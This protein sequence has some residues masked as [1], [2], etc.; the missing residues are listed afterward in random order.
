M[1]ERNNIG[2]WIDTLHALREKKTKAERVVDAVK[3]LIDETEQV[4]MTALKEAGLESARGK[5]L[6]ATLSPRSYPQ[7]EDYEKLVTHI[8]KTGAFELLQR[9]LSS[10][11]VRE[12]W[13]Q[14][15]V[16]P[17]VIAFRTTELSLTAVT[18][19]GG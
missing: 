16:V 7:I 4:V 13:D 6:Q 17:G 2:T 18:K 14:K 9:R 3:K 1:A 12:R 10:T 11:A 8:K 5:K 15:Q 19:K